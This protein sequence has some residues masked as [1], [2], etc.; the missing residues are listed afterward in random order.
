MTFMCG[1]EGLR[2]MQFGTANS[3]K[4]AFV[5]AMLVI[6]VVPS[7]GVIIPTYADGDPTATMNVWSPYSPSGTD[8]LPTSL[9]F[10]PA[11][12]LLR[13]STG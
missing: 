12:Q 6:S 11:P 1:W 10:L 7:A 8:G 5:F 3:Y 2:K 13:A 9:P 4:A